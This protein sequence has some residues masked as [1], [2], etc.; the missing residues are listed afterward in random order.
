MTSARRSGRADPVGPALAVAA[1]AAASNA[2]RA[3]LGTAAPSTLDRAWLRVGSIVSSMDGRLV[4]R[5]FIDPARP[6]AD[7]PAGEHP[8]GA[9]RS[10]PVAGPADP[11]P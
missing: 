11:S 5:W 4:A 9:A 1:V 2:V 10:Q 7:R 3:A 8:V 6:G